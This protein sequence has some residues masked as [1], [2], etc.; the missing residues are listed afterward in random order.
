MQC[1]YV[2]GDR[3]IIDTI[4]PCTLRSSICN[5]SFSTIRERHP[6]AEVWDLDEAW[7]EIEHLTYALLVKNPISITEDRWDEMLNVLPPMNWRSG[8]G[9]ESFMICEATALDLHSTFCRI[10]QQYFEMTDRQSLTHQ[11]IAEKCRAIL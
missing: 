10:G 11:E 2:P 3:H 9:S 8:S 5:E 6:N 7:Q 4:N 1:F